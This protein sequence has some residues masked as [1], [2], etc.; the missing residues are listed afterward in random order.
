MMHGHGKSDRPIVPA[1]LPNN[2][3]FEAAEAVEERG[4]AKGNAPERNM[5]RTQSRMSMFNAL[6]R[7][8][9]AGMKDGSERCYHSYSSASIGVITQGKSRMQ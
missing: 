5:S 2:A 8:R 6:E 9:Q 7:I 1:K 3:V 4:L